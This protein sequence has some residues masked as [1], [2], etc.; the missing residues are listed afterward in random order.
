METLELKNTKTLSP[1]NFFRRLIWNRFLRV[2]QPFA[3]FTFGEDENNG[4]SKTNTIK[5]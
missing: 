1:A 4:I 5:Y 2:H 3:L